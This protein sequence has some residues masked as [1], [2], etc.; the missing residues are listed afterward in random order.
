MKTTYINQSGQKLGIIIK[1]EPHP[2]KQ[3]IE[4]F[5]GVETNIINAFIDKQALDKNVIALGQRIAVLMRKQTLV[6]AECDKIYIR[7][8]DTMIDN[9]N[10]KK[11]DKYIH[12]ELDFLY[13]KL[14][15]LDSPTEPTKLEFINNLK[16]VLT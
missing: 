6:K 14:Y 16:E 10:P 13:K 9:F 2:W 8:L 7:S 12:S 4:F 1:T 5:S 15:K 3:S 11:H